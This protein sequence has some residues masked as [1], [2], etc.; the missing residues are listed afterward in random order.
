LDRPIDTGRSDGN[1]HETGRPDRNSCAENGTTWRSHL[2]D[3]SGGD[4]HGGIVA[5]YEF[6][7]GAG[8]P[9]WMARQYME[10]H[11]R[12]FESQNDVARII[13]NSIHNAMVMI[14]SRLESVLIWVG[15][16]KKHS[17]LELRS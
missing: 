3:I 9:I 2:A 16:M 6:N 10:Y 15:V 7:N 12:R 17:G 14:V 13:V 4:I 1:I 5:Y 11:R 8:I